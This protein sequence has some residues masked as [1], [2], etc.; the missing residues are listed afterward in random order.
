LTA[1]Q[2][3]V[4][5]SIGAHSGGDKTT[6]AA[7]QANYSAALQ[8]SEKVSLF[9]EVHFLASP[10]RKNNIANPL[11]SRDEAALFLTPGLRVSFWPKER[12]SPFATGGYGLGVYEQ[13]ALLQNGQ[14][15][16]RERVTRHGAAQFGGGVDVKTL[17]WLALR[18]DFRNFYSGG[19]HNPVVSIGVQVRFGE[20]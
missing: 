2:Q 10:N 19:R 4:T 8:K 12:V 17:N 6:N 15:F 18:G 11:A 5:L 16:P 7:W 3:E 13:S 20:R 14:P 1:F 9:G